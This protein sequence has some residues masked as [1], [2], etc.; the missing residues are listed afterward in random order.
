[1]CAVRVV[2]ESP[3]AFSTV[4]TPRSNSSRLRQAAIS[5]FSSGTSFVSSLSAAIKAQNVGRPVRKS[6]R[7]CALPGDV[8]GAFAL[9]NISV[10]RLRTGAE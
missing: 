1:M 6:P 4:L 3:A 8:Q 10:A 5:A 2:R 7:K 9:E